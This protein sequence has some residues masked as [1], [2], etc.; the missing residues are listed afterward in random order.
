MKSTIISLILPALA[1]ANPLIA[2][3]QAERAKFTGAVTTS[4][5]GCPAGSA[6]ATF[7][8]G[9]F[10]NETATITLSVYRVA[11]GPN[12]PSDQREKDCKV[13]LPIHFPLGCTRV[14]FNSTLTGAY[15]LNGDRV[16]GS[17]TRAY[18]LSPGQLQGGNPPALTF[19][20]PFPAPAYIQQDGFVG[21]ENIRNVNEQT[22]SFSLQGRLSLQNPASQSGELSNDVWSV[23]TA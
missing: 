1:L 23:K 13:E 22:V 11:V 16:T 17:Y 3:R 20:Q 5:A 18:V 19:P 8:S 7:S 6:T 15:Q 9:D 14:N 12:V 10:L 2:T 21:T 4:G